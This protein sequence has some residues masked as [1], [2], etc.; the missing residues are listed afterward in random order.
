MKPGIMVPF[1]KPCT[2]NYPLSPS[3]DGYT[4]YIG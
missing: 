4:T 1:G 2:G 3:N